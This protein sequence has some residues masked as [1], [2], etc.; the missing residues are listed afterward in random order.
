MNTIDAFAISM[1]AVVLTG[2]GVVGLIFFNMARCA[3]GHDPELEELMSEALKP[4]DEEAKIQK[5]PAATTTPPRNEW[6]RDTDWW[7]KDG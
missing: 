3:R 2:F 1:L 6:E 7:R 5:K 4:E